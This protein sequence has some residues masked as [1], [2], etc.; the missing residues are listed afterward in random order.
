MKKFIFHICILPII[1]YKLAL[2]KYNSSCQGLA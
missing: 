2:L 1:L